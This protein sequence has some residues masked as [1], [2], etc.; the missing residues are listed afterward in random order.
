MKGIR[1]CATL[2]NIASLSDIYSR[3][4]NLMCAFSFALCGRYRRPTQAASLPSLLHLRNFDQISRRQLTSENG[5]HMLFTAI[6]SEDRSQRRARPPG[7]S[8][9][10]QFSRAVN[11]RALHRSALWFLARVPLPPWGRGL[12]GGG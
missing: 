4:P 5:R 3:R 7:R 6:L 12:G 2:A 11:P 9:L 1:R 8:A 10:R